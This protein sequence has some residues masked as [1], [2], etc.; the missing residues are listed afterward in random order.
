MKLLK[1]KKVILPVIGIVFVVAGL[2]GLLSHWEKTITPIINPEPTQATGNIQDK[3]PTLVEEYQSGTPENITIP[4]VG[5]NLDVRLGYYNAN[6][7]TW[8]LSETSAHYATITKP[9]NNKEGNT[10][11]YGHNLP[12]VFEPLSGLRAGDIALI[13]TDN[14]KTFKY[15]LSRVTTASPNDTAVLNYSGAPVLT[16]QTCSGAWYE[17]RSLYWFDYVEVV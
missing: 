6:S 9:A 4:A 7:Q 12:K 10:F 13:G 14:G 2:L 1:F 16:V 15:R 5:V 3:M 11:I 17:K 8:T